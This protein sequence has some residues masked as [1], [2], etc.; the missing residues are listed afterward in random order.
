MLAEQVKL[1]TGKPFYSEVAD[2]ASVIFDTTI[3][4]SIVKHAVRKRGPRFDT[5]SRKRA[6]RLLDSRLT[7]SDFERIRKVR[8]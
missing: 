7:G 8:G 1:Y 5:M 6:E 3:D 4:E 2:L